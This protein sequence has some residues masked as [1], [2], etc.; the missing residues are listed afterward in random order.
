MRVIE[1]TR[2]Y[3]AIVDDE[4]FESLA[5]YRWRANINRKYSKT[6]YA[7]RSVHF[8][9]GKQKT[10]SMHRLI[11][12]AP[13]NFEVDHMNGNGLDNRRSNLRLVTRTQ[14]AQNRS[15]TKG[16]KLP[17]GVFYIP[18]MKT[19][20]FRATIWANKKIHPLGFYETLEEA[21]EAY[22]KAAKQ[23]HGEFARLN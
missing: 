22:N 23:H 16:S 14:N 4:D 8:G 3:A 6:V 9:N 17:K 13:P 20:K 10:V 5:Q 11:L 12:K 21:K 1:L 18:K 19:R 15:Q 2:G 7:I